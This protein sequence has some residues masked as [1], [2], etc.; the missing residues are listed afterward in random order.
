MTQKNSRTSDVENPFTKKVPVPPPMYPKRGDTWADN[1]LTWLK[2]YSEKGFNCFPVVPGEK[3]PAITGY[4]DLASSDYEKLIT[5][6]QLFGGKFRHHEIG[7]LVGEWVIVVD[8]DDGEVEDLPDT[9]TATSQNRGFHYFLKVPEGMTINTCKLPEINAD[10]KALNATGKPSYVILPSE[11]N[12]R[13][14]LEGKTPHKLGFA[15]APE[16][17]L[18]MIEERLSIPSTSYHS[19][20]QQELDL[21]DEELLSIIARSKN[22]DRFLDLFNGDVSK[23]DNDYSAA[24]QAFLAHCT[25]ISHDPETLERLLRSSQLWR[26]KWD[27]DDWVSRSIDNALKLE[28]SIHDPNAYKRKALDIVQNIPNMRFSNPNEFLIFRS[29][30]LNALNVYRYYDK[31][32]GEIHTACSFRDIEKLSGVRLQHIQTYRDRLVKDGKLRIVHPSNGSEA[33]SYAIACSIDDASVTNPHIANTATNT[34]N[35]I[36]NS[37]NNKAITSISDTE[38]GMCLYICNEIGTKVVYQN[39]LNPSQISAVLLISLGIS[40]ALL[41][42][43]VLGYKDGRKFERKHLQPL[44]KE[45]YLTYNKRKRTYSLHRYI[46]KTLEKNFDS[47]RYE[48][49]LERIEKE[50]K[51]HKENLSTNSEIGKVIPDSSTKMSPRERFMMHTGKSKNKTRDVVQ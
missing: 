15:L 10:I 11:R 28:I 21:E 1:N 20:E 44:L 18:Q 7:T 31:D 2:F 45:N 38:G 30:N 6:P 29:I 40:D 34:K 33:T 35:T 5:D 8:G 50:R 14:W 46:E 48:S 3:R 49:T 39:S 26:D 9:T 4:Q 47:E 23:Y 12:R 42:G 27:R 32:A 36:P 16:W 41:L 19:S 13:E 22:G 43:Q 24:A 37:T 17:L 25:K 51:A